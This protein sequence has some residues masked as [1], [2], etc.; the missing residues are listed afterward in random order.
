M[1]CPVN[2]GKGS[3]GGTSL[4]CRNRGHATRSLSRGQ[5][6]SPTE[7]CHDSVPLACPKQR[8]PSAIRWNKGQWKNG[9]DV[10]QRAKPLVSASDAEPLWE[11][12]TGGLIAA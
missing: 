7:S 1:I 8:V 5:R 4:P 6:G 10:R 11:P 12:W 9:S 3:G 2:G